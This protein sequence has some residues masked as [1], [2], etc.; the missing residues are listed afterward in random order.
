[1]PNTL[2][3][4]WMK[5]VHKRLTCGLSTQIRDDTEG[6]LTDVDKRPSFEPIYTQVLWEM[7]CSKTLIYK[8]L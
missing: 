1:M 5:A 4:L 8:E 3:G 6:V 7:K 2:N